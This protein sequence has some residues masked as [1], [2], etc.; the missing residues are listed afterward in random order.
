MADLG[1]FLADIYNP[2]AFCSIQHNFIFHLFYDSVIF[3]YRWSLLFEERRIDIATVFTRQGQRI[4][5]L[6]RWYLSLDLKMYL[7][8]NVPL[9]VD[10]PVMCTQY[11]MCLE[12]RRQSLN[13]KTLV[14]IVRINNHKK[15]LGVQIWT[16]SVNVI[17]DTPL[18]HT[19]TNYEWGA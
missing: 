4:I 7:D 18:E 3:F 9:C 12:H 17:S 6:G 8:L 5:C 10:V 15:S 19:S 13:I 16:E 14:H 2:I 11:G 1:T